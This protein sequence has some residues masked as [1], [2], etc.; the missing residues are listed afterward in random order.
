MKGKD[1]NEDT[2]KEYY[3]L[4]F[5]VPVNMCHS[6]VIFINASVSN[7]HLSPSQRNCFLNSHKLF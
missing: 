3:Y 5:K 1:K 2:Y 4:K 6:L 7:I